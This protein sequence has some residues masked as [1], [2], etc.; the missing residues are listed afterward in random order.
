M[1]IAIVSQDWKRTNCN[2]TQ[3]SAVAFAHHAMMLG[4]D[5]QMVAFTKSGKASSDFVVPG[6]ELQT[7][8]VYEA[9]RVLNRF[10][11]IF[12][13]SVGRRP[14]K[15]TVELIQVADLHRPFVFMVHGEGDHV[16][17]HDGIETIADH[18]CCRGVAVVSAEAADD[19]RLNI[20][21]KV[22][23]PCTIPPYLLGPK[24]SWVSS[25]E[26]YGLVYAAR[27]VNYK[28]PQVLAQLTRSDDFMEACQGVV[29]LHGVPAGRSGAQLE[30]KCNS[31]GPRW[32]R[33]NGSKPSG[34]YDI[35]DW[36]RVASM[37][38]NRRFYWDVFKVKGVEHYFRRWNLGAVEAARFGAIPIVNP[39]MAPEWSHSFSVLLDPN[40]WRAEDVISQMHEI[41]QDIEHYRSLMRQRLLEGPYSRYA[42]QRQVESILDL[43]S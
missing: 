30:D 12:F 29:E 15:D 41:N 9:Q 39:R 27:I 17:Y 1:R 2:G 40:D 8:S 5:A 32:S 43:L 26:T 14:N 34:Y 11:A 3:T 24:N 13:S 38:Q 20:P 37:F 35:Y 19:L 21:I 23:Y 33:R 31:Y 10:E 7:Y 4:H 6:C 42:V 22:F 36:M 25:G 18:A 16:A 28:Q